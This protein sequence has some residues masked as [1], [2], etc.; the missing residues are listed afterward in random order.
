MPD[1]SWEPHHVIVCGWKWDGSCNMLLGPKHPCLCV[2]VSSHACRTD[3]IVIMKLFDPVP[4]Q[5]ILMLPAE[6]RRRKNILYYINYYIRWTASL[7]S[8]CLYE[9]HAKKFSLHAVVFIPANFSSLPSSHPAILVKWL[10]LV[11]IFTSSKCFGIVAMG[12]RWLEG[13]RRKS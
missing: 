4:V 13:K 1:W 10:L 3:S 8:Y 11:I 2:T 5:S 9:C 6:V 12:K 7:S